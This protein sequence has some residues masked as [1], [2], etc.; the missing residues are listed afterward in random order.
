MIFFGVSAQASFT[1][2]RN[3]ARQQGSGQPYGRS[4]DRAPWPFVM[5]AAADLLLLFLGILASKDGFP[6]TPSKTMR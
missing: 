2:S 1:C 4:N 6:N 3:E 5:L